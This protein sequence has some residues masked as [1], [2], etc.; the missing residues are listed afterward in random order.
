MAMPSGIGIIDLMMGLP[1]GDPKR[2]YDFLKKQLHDRESREEFEFPAQYMF[3]E[4]PKFEIPDDPARFLLDN[5][6]RFGVER[7]MIGVNFQHEA[8]LK[9]LADHPD[10]FFGSLEVDPNRGMEGVFELVRAVEEIGVKAAT[11]FPAGMSPQ[12]P[13]NDARFYPYYA[14]CVE[15]DIPIFVCAGVPGPR[16]PMN[17]QYVGHIDEV[18]YYFPD[19]K[20]V[21]RH[22]CEPWADLAVKLM[23]KWPNLY[24]STS[25]FAPKH[26]PEDIVHYANTR[27]ADKILYAGYFPMGLSLDRIMADMLDVPFRDHVW[28]KF[29]RENAM[30]VLGLD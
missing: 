22:G 12:V 9:A 30:R 26:Y 19:L 21:T 8:A 16:V 4:V 10:R 13:I 1:A 27:G 14:K 5:M 23:L 29:L 25:A 3:K 24:Y 15:L 11:A 28:P 20:F 6:D 18:C 17:C 7:A 2:W